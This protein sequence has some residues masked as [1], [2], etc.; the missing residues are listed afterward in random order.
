MKLTPQMEE[1]LALQQATEPGKRP[2]LMGDKDTDIFQSILGDLKEAVVS[3]IKTKATGWIM[4]LVG[5]GPGPDP[6]DAIKDQL[7][8]QY[9]E[10]KVIEGKIDALSEQLNVAVEALKAEIDGAKYYSAIQALNLSISDIDAAYERLQFYAKTE[11]GKASKKE[12][13]E[14][15]TNIRNT[16]P[17]AF[18]AVKNNLLGTASGGENLTSLGTRIA[19]KAAKT[20]EEYGEIINLQFMYYYGMQVKALMLIIEAYH[21][22]GTEAVAKEYFNNYVGQMN[23]EI[24]IYLS[25]A[26]KCK[27][28]STVTLASDPMGIVVKGDMVYVQSGFQNDNA[29]LQ[30]I[31]KADLQIKNTL[32]VPDVRANWA[33]LEKDGFAYLLSMAGSDESRWDITKVSL[34]GEPKVQGKL[35]YSP[36]GQGYF[37]MGFLTGAAIEGDYLYAMFMALG[38]KGFTIKVIDLKTFTYADDIR[39]SDELQ[40][41]G[42]IGANGLA[43]KDGKIYIPAWFD[44]DSFTS[45]KVID[46]KTKTIIQSL[47]AEPQSGS[48]GQS[49]VLI[50]GDLLYCVN[51]DRSLRIVNIAK[52]PIEINS[53]TYVNSYVQNI[54]VDGYLIYYVSYSGTAD[55]RGTLNV[56]YWTQKSGFMQKSMAVGNGISAVTMDSNTIYAGAGGGEKAL[57]VLNYTQDLTGN[58][59][60]LNP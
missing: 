46:V 55:T 4:N 33:M 26:P 53:N 48:S 8:K 29:C 1:F 21:Y 43:V 23:E 22:D 47:K 30:T 37:R 28:R 12:M 31:G 6:L 41:A 17:N 7:N 24:K 54:L 20:V 40:S 56:I 60:P 10:L 45:I 2:M 27:L 49:P 3:K 42:S 25:F 32:T 44:K 11:P 19:F 34:G 9:A 18:I 38:E 16:I 13:D 50:K 39:I 35:T 5:M 51:G 59:I 52:K 15:A 14:L 57:Y 58:I 36:P